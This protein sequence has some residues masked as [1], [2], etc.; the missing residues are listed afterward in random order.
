MTSA[1]DTSPATA[2]DSAANSWLQKSAAWL[3]SVGIPTELGSSSPPEGERSTT[4]RLKATLRRGNEALSPRELRRLLADLQAVAASEVSDAEGGRLAEPVMQWY[5]AAQPE[6]RMDCW[7]LLCEQFVPDVA[8]IGQARQRY[9][10]AVGTAGMAAAERQLRK[11]LQT[12]RMR[13]LQRF[14][15][16]A[17]GMRFLLDLRAQ[18][19]PQ[20]KSHEWLV[21][22]DADLE[23][24]F[25]TW[26]DIAFLELRSLSWDSPASLLEKLI[27]YEAV[28]DIRSWTDLK[29]RLDSDRRC[30]HEVPGG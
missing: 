24:L 19:L 1:T 17:Q 2:V 28:H 30:G 7:R 22:V 26:F 10:D 6:Q 16:P 4:E 9:E 21:A 23:Y 29:N 13:L 14:A 12:P 8:K 27:K 3:R 25:S 11:A 15:V 5:A 20:L 18:M